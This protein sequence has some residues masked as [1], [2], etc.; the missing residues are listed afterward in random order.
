MVLVVLGV[1]LVVLEVVLVVLVVVM[2]GR[3]LS[4][5]LGTKRSGHKSFT[6]ALKAL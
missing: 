2:E 3:N 6:G 4:Y 1:V 5:R